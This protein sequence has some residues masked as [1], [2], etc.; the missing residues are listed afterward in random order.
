MSHNFVKQSDGLRVCSYC[1]DERGNDADRDC[2]PMVQPGNN[3][4][5]VNESPIPLCYLVAY[6]PYLYFIL[7]LMNFI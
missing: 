2:P 1:G 6:F 7:R 4:V 5:L 3:P